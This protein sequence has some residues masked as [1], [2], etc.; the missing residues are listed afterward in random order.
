MMIFHPTHGYHPVQTVIGD[1]SG[2]QYTRIAQQGEPPSEIDILEVRKEVLVEAPSMQKGVPT[3]QHRSAA[4]EQ[5]GIF[6]VRAPDRLAEVA[7]PRVTDEGDDATNEVDALARPV[8]NL[9]R[10][11]RRVMPLGGGDELAQ[12]RGIDAGVVVEQGH[13]LA[14]TLAGRRVVGDTE[15]AIAVERKDAD[16][17][18]ALTHEL[19]RAVSRPVVDEF[20]LEAILRIDLALQ[21]R[22]TRVEILAAVS[23]ENQDRDPGRAH[24]AALRETGA[25]GS[26]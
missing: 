15:S 25:V 11:G 5:E 17:R 9:R 21:T 10:H 7:L 19:R 24:R 14:G 12:P 2:R 1:G 26:R 20:D 8:Q 22:H 13:E 16:L 6:C 3:D 23:I 18:K 4:R